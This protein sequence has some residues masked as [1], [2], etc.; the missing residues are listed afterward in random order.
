M[1]PHLQGWD[2]MNK[3][4]IGIDVSKNSFDLCVFGT[5]KVESWQY[6]S[7]MLKKCVRQLKKLEPELIVM[8]ATGGYEMELTIALQQAQLA[9]AVVN[10]RR[11]RD[12][13]KAVGQ[14]AKTDKV[15]AR[16]IARFAATLH[17]PTTKMITESS[18]KIKALVTRRS[19]LIKMRTSESNRQE[20]ATEKFVTRS[21]KAS[22]TRITKEIKTIDE[23]IQSCIYK[24]PEMKTTA[25]IVQTMV[26][27]GK[28]T[29][30]MLVSEL[31]ELGTLTRREIA[32]LIGVAP[33]ARESGTFKGKRMT[34]G[35]R[36]NIRTQ[37]YMP[38]LVAIQHNQPIREFYNRLISNGKTKMTAVV[39]CM[40]KIITILNVM[41][42]KK[43][44]WKF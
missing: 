30:A 4:F 12:F 7:Q 31:P 9:V 40:R 21:L 34:G 29:S 19:Q 23:E 20:H 16:I 5:N 37:L 27:I 1:N 24:D 35:G 10:P 17:P 36:Q 2:I 14:M 22:I 26:G 41:V 8:E 39:A 13:A 33:I 25:N 18:L 6:T 3:K 44:C 38:T 32:S 43:E 15:D 42:S 28:I 11:V